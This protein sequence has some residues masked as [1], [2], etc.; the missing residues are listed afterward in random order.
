MHRRVRDPIEL[1]PI[2]RGD[3][4][5]R[6]AAVPHHPHLNGYCGTPGLVPA[7]FAVFLA[8][9]TWRLVPTTPVDRP[10]LAGTLLVIVQAALKRDKEARGI[11]LFL[12]QTHSGCGV[13]DSEGSEAIS[14][15]VGGRYY[16][17]FN[18]IGGLLRPSDRCR[19]QLGASVLEVLTWLVTQKSASAERQDTTRN[20]S[21]HASS[22]D[23]GAV[24]PEPPARVGA[25]AGDL[26]D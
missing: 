1:R 8:A 11:S 13:V 20:S 19:L 15:R 5:G 14:P 17:A 25:F 16:V 6:S 9:S 18:V 4:H 12:Y 26:S 7:H 22:P 3:S 10:G 23:T 24:L 21:G 2:L